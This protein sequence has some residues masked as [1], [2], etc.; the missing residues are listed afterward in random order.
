M[1]C[2]RPRTTYV[3]IRPLVQYLLC[4]GLIFSRFRIITALHQFSTSGQGPLL[5]IVVNAYFCQKFGG[6]KTISSTQNSLVKQLVQLKE[7]SRE[8]RKSGLF[9]LEGIRELQ[10]AVKA[11]YQIQHIWFDPEIIALDDLLKL[12]I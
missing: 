9:V 8:R 12:S 2:I 4:F 11:G 5:R 6:L 3:S 10:L 1:K 7:K